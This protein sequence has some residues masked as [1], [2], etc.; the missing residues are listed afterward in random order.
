MAELDYF[1]LYTD[2]YLADTGHLTGAQHGAYFLLLVTAWRNQPNLS[3]PDD[4]V[5]LARYTRMTLSQWR[6]MR[7]IIEQF[8]VV[9]NGVWTQSHLN[10]IYKAIK[11]KK[12]SGLNGAA[13]R[14][15]NNNK[16]TH[17]IASDPHMRNGCDADAKP[18]A[19]K[20]K[21]KGLYPPKAPP[22][23]DKSL[24]GGYS[25]S[26]KFD[27]LGAIDEKAIETAKAKAKGW[28]IYYLANIYNSGVERRGIPKNPA[29]AFIGWCSRYT[30]GKSP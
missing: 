13:A 5:W 9:D 19:S 15:L 10:D 8:F 20:T 24:S 1:P 4:D 16:T 29:G 27:I 2:A 11:Q 14:W 17:A 12:K 30:K 18:M 7:P 22:Y 28:D 6:K 23:V 25:G 21:S 26:N 3:L